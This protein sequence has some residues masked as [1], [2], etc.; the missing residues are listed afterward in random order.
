MRSK[1]SLL[2]WECLLRHAVINTDVITS[3]LS[4]QRKQN[5][6]GPATHLKQALLYASSNDKI[7]QRV[8][9]YGRR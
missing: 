8:A 3:A 5:M 9:H 4:C 7:S 2:L 6:Q 1:C